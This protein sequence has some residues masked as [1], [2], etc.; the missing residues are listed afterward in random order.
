MI[1]VY[2]VAIA[3]LSIL[4][5]TPRTPPDPVVNGRTLSYW[6][7]SPD[8]WG[9]SYRYQVFQA[10]LESGKEGIPLLRNWLRSGNKLERTIVRRAPIW[11]WKCFPKQEAEAYKWAAIAASRENTTAKHLLRELELFLDPK[12]IT[13][14][15]AAAD[16]F[17][18][19][20]KTKAQ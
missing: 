13:A 20:S 17:L 9:E 14:G 3:G 19:G 8:Y 10:V 4:F 16:A 7:T 2:A 5:L 15:N 1:A 6:L 12:D 18:S 11:F